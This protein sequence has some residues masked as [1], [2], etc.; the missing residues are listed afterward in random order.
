MTSREARRL[1]DVYALIDICLSIALEK[2]KGDYKE[3]AN[4]TNLHL[5]TL[6]RLAS[7]NFTLGIHVRTLV[8]LAEAAGFKVELSEAAIHL[9]V[10]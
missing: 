5:S 7:H 1:K 10:R 2:A 6:Y 3:V 8:S 9:K 4:R